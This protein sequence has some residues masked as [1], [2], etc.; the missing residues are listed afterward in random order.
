M[1]VEMQQSVTIFLLT[2]QAARFLAFTSMADVAGGD[3]EGVDPTTQCCMQSL[4]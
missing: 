4:S 2:W 1:H 3:Q